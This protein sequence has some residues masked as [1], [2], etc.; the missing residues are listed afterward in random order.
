MLFI[1]VPSLTETGLYISGNKPMLF[2]SLFGGE[3]GGSIESLL[4]LEY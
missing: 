3:G 2:F 4:S 1:I